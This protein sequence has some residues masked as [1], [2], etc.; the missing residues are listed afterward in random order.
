MFLREDVT[1]ARRCLRIGE[2]KGRGK[3]GMKVKGGWWVSRCTD[4]GE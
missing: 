1:T 3:T 4:D 2:Q